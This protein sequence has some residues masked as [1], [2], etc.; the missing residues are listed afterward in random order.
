[1]KPA[2][3]GKWKWLWDA[4]DALEFGDTWFVSMEQL[5]STVLNPHNNL[6]YTYSRRTGRSI[7]YLTVKAPKA[8]LLFVRLDG[9]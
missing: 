6:A 8:G 1:M 3:K 4:L 9:N 2:G 7:G 5:Q